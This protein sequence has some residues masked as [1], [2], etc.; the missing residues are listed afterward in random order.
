MEG[1]LPEDPVNTL[2]TVTKGELHYQITMAFVE[3]QTCQD[4]LA[5]AT[6]TTAIYAVRGQNIGALRDASVKHGIYQVDTEVKVTFHTVPEDGSYVPVFNG[7]E[8][9]DLL[10]RTQTRGRH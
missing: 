2:D 6:A 5:A 1:L 3:G 7:T 8:M 9:V 10:S 4:V